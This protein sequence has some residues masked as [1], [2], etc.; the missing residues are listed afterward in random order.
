[1]DRCLDEAG[2]FA[3]FSDLKMPALR[4]SG[5]KWHYRTNWEAFE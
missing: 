5:R 1:M 4:R 3:R 2:R